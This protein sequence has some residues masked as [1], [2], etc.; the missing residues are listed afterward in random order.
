M[1]YWPHYYDE[2]IDMCYKMQVNSKKIELF[3]GYLFIDPK[4]KLLKHLQQYT[5]QMSL[6]KFLEDALN[7]KVMKDQGKQP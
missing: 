7:L 5:N 3:S 1:K 4:T 6:A 2:V